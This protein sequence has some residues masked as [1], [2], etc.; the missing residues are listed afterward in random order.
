VYRR[1]FG[2]SSRANFH[3]DGLDP[4]GDRGGRRFEEKLQRLPEV[5]QGFLSG[6]AL[7]GYVHLGPLGNEL[8]PLAPDPCYKPLLHREEYSRPDGCLAPF[9]DGGGSVQCIHP[10]L[11]GRG[12]GRGA[13]CWGSRAPKHSSSPPPG[14]PQEG[15]VNL[16]EVFAAVACSRLGVNMFYDPTG[17]ESEILGEWSR[18][19]P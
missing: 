19:R 10:F 7:A 18:I 13:T 14:L 8:L 1:G 12:S 9:L 17:P 5:G 6:A 3:L 4:R 16:S 2:D 15:E 11:L